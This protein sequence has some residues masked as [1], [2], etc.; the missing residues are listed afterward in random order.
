MK[1][2]DRKTM[3]IMVR[4]FNPHVVFLKV[5]KF[6]TIRSLTPMISSKLYFPNLQSL[7]Y[8]FDITCHLSR[9]REISSSPEWVCSSSGQ[10]GSHCS[11][12]GLKMLTT[13]PIS[14][15]WYGSRVVQ[16]FANST[17][18]IMFSMV[19][20]SG[21][22]VWSIAFMI[23]SL[24][25]RIWQ[26]HV[27]RWDPSSGIVLFIAFLPVISSIKTTPNA[28]TSTLAVTLPVAVEKK[29]N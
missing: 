16:Y 17:T 2:F 8:S 20:S 12:K 23:F 5:S 26:N 1:E 29:I 25:I 11:T 9:V 18:L 3:Y 4:S 13:C 21:L 27:T 19:S 28:Y 14:G 6:H 24:L 22:R 10:V 15:L 7:S